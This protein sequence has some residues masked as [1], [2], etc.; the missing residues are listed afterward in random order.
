[1]EIERKWLIDGF[2]ED[3]KINLPC[4]EKADVWQ[5]YISQEP[6]VRIREVRQNGESRF[7]MC[8]KGK[9]ELAREEI[10]DEISLEFFNKLKQFIGGNLIHKQWRVYRLE[11][12]ENLEVSLV[13]EGKDTSFYYAEVEFKSEGEANDFVPPKFL[14]K[15]KTYSDNFS[16]SK[17]WSK[18]RLK[19]ADK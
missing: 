17:Y 13:D 18:T 6:T 8:V 16:M 19:K 14:G 1:M 7:I 9:G 5:G 3:I 11:S 15:E 2:L 4:I 10:E 12:G